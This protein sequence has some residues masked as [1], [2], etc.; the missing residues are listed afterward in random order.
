LAAPASFSKGRAVKSGA[1]PRSMRPGPGREVGLRTRRAGRR[2]LACR[3]V[4]A[5]PPRRSR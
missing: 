5:L 2:A 1:D 3:P 4:R